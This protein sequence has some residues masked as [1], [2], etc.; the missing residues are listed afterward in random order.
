MNALQ[1]RR[2]RRLQLPRR[3]VPYP[4]GAVLAPATAVTGLKPAVMLQA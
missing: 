3:R 2:Q 1:A 4:D